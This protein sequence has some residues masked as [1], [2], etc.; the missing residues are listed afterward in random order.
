[1]ATTACQLY[2][3]KIYMSAET[4]GAWADVRSGVGFLGWSPLDMYIQIWAFIYSSNYALHRG[5]MCFDSSAV[6]L[7]Y[8][9]LSAT[10]YYWV[11]AHK[12]ANGDMTWAQDTLQI[13]HVPAMTHAVPPVIG[14]WATLTPLNSPIASYVMAE[15][16]DEIWVSVSLDAGT[17]A[18][19]NIGGP[20]WFAGKSKYDTDNSAPAFRKFHGLSWARQGGGGGGPYAYLEIVTSDAISKSL[21]GSMSFSGAL[22]S[23]KWCLVSTDAASDITPHGATLN[24]ELV[25]ISGRASV[26]VY[27]EYGLSTGVYTYTTSA[28]TLVGVGM[29]D[30]DI[31]Y[32]QNDT[33]YYFRAVCDDGTHV[34]YGSELTFD[35][36]TPS[37]SLAKTLRTPDRGITLKVNTRT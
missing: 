11:G 34:T 17:I 18:A 9:V 23:D 37:G 31:A 19:L 35:T 8:T 13:F 15:S 14:D 10:L 36:T 24:G 1:M 22:T 26:D 27:F 28:Q 2:L 4:P 30:A 32:L 21:S 12:W 33:T 29:F 5:L 6:P 16:Q 25:D 7:G 3:N 20:I